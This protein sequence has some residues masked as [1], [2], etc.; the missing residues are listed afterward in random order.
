VLS[1][2]CAV[3]PGSSRLVS[4]LVVRGTHN[5][6]VNSRVDGVHVGSPTP[7]ISDHLNL[8]YVE[9]T[10]S[11]DAVGGVAIWALALAHSW[12]S[13]SRAISEIQLNMRNRLVIITLSLLVVGALSVIL[14]LLA[15]TPHYYDS[16]K[17]QLLISGGPCCSAPRPSEGEVTARNANGQSFAVSVPATGRFVLQLAAGTYWL[18]GSSPQFGGGQYKCLAQREVTV[19]KG[20]STHEDVLCAE[21]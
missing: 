1:R 9:R 14:T 7:A 2:S 4:S 3:H 6:E 8:S 5:L 19:S 10:S 13:C 16:V 17:G 20:K 12:T 15:S 21:K 11:S 18:T